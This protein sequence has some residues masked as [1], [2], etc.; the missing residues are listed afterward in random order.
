ML[1]YTGGGFGGSLPNIPA[2]DLDD[3]EIKLYGW[4]A[5]A[6]VAS[7]LYERAE[8][9]VERPHYQDKNEA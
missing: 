5:E 2:R 1:R 7:G 3:E 4:D 6:L 8:T 9:K